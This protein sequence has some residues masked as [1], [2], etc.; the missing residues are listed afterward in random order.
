MNPKREPATLADAIQYVKEAHDRLS[1]LIEDPEASDE[2]LRD[3][4][5]ALLDALNDYYVDGP[6]GDGR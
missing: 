3:A 4:T 2:K 6:R 1:D 5:V